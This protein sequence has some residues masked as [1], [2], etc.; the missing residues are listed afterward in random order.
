M[1]TLHDMHRLNASCLCPSE[2][3]NTR[4]AGW[5]LMNFISDDVEKS[6]MVVSIFTYIDIIKLYFHQ[7]FN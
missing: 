6:R 7:R 2:C 5:I 4:T 3:V 1:R